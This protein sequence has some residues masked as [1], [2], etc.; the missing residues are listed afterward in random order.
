MTKIAEK[1]RSAAPVHRVWRCAAQTGD[2]Y[3]I[4]WS[5][6]AG[7]GRPIRRRELARDALRTTAEGA[8]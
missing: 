5:T 1:P 2:R 8:W 7:P 3:A 6:A 4:T